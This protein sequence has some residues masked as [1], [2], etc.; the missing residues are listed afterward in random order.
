MQPSSQNT[1]LVKCVG[2]SWHWGIYIIQVILPRTVMRGEIE[3]QL[4][5]YWIFCDICFKESFIG[6]VTF[7]FKLF[8]FLAPDDPTAAEFRVGGATE[9]ATEEVA[10]PAA[11]TRGSSVKASGE[12]GAG[13]SC[14]GGARRA[15]TLLVG[16]SA[17]VCFTAGQSSTA[18]WV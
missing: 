15:A 10:V 9:T 11:G 2:F 16:R 13:H 4:H 3:P 8:L 12:D 6:A 18:G 14:C 5:T 1:F 7:S 17:A